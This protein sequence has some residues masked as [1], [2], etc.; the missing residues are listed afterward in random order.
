MSDCF[1]SSVTPNDVCHP[2]SLEREGERLKLEDQGA[3][4]EEQL[5]GT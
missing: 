2:E 5:A 3:L 1:S 4:S